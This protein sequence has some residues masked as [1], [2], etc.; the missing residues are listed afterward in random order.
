[1]VVSDFKMKGNGSGLWAV[2]S[3]KDGL[4]YEGTIV[5]EAPFGL[6]LSIG[7]DENRLYLFPWDKI[8][9]VI[10]KSVS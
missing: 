2:V 3:L 8:E 1:M 10:Y 9:K 7:G 4:V 5:N 6:Y